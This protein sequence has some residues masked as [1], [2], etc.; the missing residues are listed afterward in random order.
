M[1]QVSNKKL[2]RK[3]TLR[4][5]KANKTRNLVAIL[6][7]ALTTI[8]FTSLCSVAA[9]L[10]ASIEQQT[11]RQV[12]TDFH[13]GFKG[14]TIE[15]AHLIAADK[16]VEVVG[17]K[18]SLGC[19]N[20]EP[21][22]KVHVE[23]RYM[24]NNDAEHSFCTPN[25]GK[26]PEET[27]GQELPEVATDT[28]VLQLLEITPEIGA[29]VPLTYELGN[30]TKITQRFS[31]SGWW[32]YDGASNASMVLVSK[33]Y[34]EQVLEGYTP[35]EGDETGSWDVNVMFDSS[36]DLEEKAVQILERQGLQNEDSL[37]QNY[38]DIGINWGYS[39]AQLSNNMDFVTV[40]AIVTL[41]IM[42]GATGYL[43]IYNIFRISVT[44]DIRFYG[45]L[46][47]I[48]TTKKQ[49]RK[50]ILFQALCLSAAGI[51]IGLILGFFIGNV[52]TP[53]IMKSLTYTTS[54]VSAN[55]LL[56][57]AAAV[58]SLIT[59]L[60]SCLKP[61]GIA[62]KVSP[63]EAVRYTENTSIKKKNKKGKKGAKLINMAIANI[64]RS[65][66][67]TGLV[68][69]SLALSAMLFHLTF[70]FANGFDM[71]KYTSKF[72]ASD[73]VIGSVNYFNRNQGMESNDVV[74]SDVIDEMNSQQEIT[75]SGRVYGMF[76]IVF[77]EFSMEQL[78]KFY[79][80]RGM[81]NSVI[82]EENNNG[83]NEYMVDIYGMDEFPLSM[84]EVLEGDVSKVND[85]EENYI[86]EVLFAD[87]YGNPEVETDIHEIG[88]KITIHYGDKYTFY[89]TRTGEEREDSDESIPK[90]YIG[91]KDAERKSVSYTVCAKV[92]VP[93]A[94]S[95]RAY[96]GK[97][98]ILGAES[99]LRDT[100][101]DT[102]MIYAMDVEDDKEA[103]MEEYIND[104]TT[105]VNPL[106]DYESKETYA[107]EFED[108]RN[109]FVIVGGAL[110]FIV[111]LVGILN[112][113]NS[114]LTGINA[115]RRE[116]AMMQAVGMTGK[117]LKKMLI[118]EGLL[119]TGIAIVITFLLSVSV[120]PVLLNVLSEIIWFF[121]GEMTILPLLVLLPV[122]AL[123]GA[124]VPLLLYKSI[125]KTSI[126]E[127][128][129]VVE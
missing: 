103:E 30:G 121:S 115:R 28:R 128:L 37:A 23:I 15:Q 110:A 24:D 98:Y 33:G 126:V 67:K 65:K 89:D 36:F 77:A 45:L 69:A 52:L 62:G 111:G 118:Y 55:P 82:T 127:R 1:F 41:L 116:F 87:D 129:R 105:N 79:T 43:I 83:K 90:E 42:I 73:F 122:Y 68:V 6:A 97:Q 40:V 99:F 88:D 57:V 11:F 74:T 49:I 95:Y 7:I 29:V 114:I 10:N 22:N 70:T 123:I 18:R 78:D 94:I 12:G 53:V 125:S 85:T 96:G 2:I 14:V 44:G 19:V 25:S 59:V 32:E 120:Q 54:V 16:S 27:E 101:K 46:K 21:F 56:F 66:T 117:Q 35:A 13:V 8:L 86:I 51:L 113:T 61:A 107:K 91:V 60:I 84:L 119:Y 38:V 102:V 93:N 81:E 4:N 92:L 75:K 20:E 31:L 76:D 104:Y 47:T 50:M 5:L 9:S 58:F 80:Q 72:H 108:F 63:V 124:G 17:Y 109:M 3:L 112:F 71:D 64:G 106:Y 48:G 39:S 100:G 26:L 34:C